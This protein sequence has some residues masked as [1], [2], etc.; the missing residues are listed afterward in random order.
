VPQEKSA[1]LP[2]KLQGYWMTLTRT[3]GWLEGLAKATTVA[4]M[5]LPWGG[6]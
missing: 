2:L 4:V 5:P 6:F 1:L 3:R